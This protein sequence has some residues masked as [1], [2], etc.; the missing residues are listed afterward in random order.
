M[1]PCPS[2]GDEGNAFDWF[3]TVCE[4]CGCYKGH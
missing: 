1:V 4:V 2:C 3:E